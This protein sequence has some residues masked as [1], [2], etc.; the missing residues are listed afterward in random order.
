MKE[1]YDIGEKFEAWSQVKTWD[2][3]INRLAY[4]GQNTPISRP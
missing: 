4:F 2:A 1:I 3:K